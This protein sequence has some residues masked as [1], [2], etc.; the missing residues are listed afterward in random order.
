MLFFT[1]SLG[2]TFNFN[3]TFIPT[4]HLGS[5]L[6]A[7]ICVWRKNTGKLTLFTHTQL[8]SFNLPFVKSWNLSATRMFIWRNPFQHIQQKH[9]VSEIGQKSRF[10]LNIR[11]ERCGE[12]KQRWTHRNIEFFCTLLLSAPP[13]CSSCMPVMPCL[14]FVC[15]H[16]NMISAQW[17]CLCFPVSWHHIISADDLIGF[18]GEE[19]WWSGRSKA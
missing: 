9:W 15:L 14:C 7:W 16:W 18:Y 2:K 13:V 4:S 12:A 8:Y 17:Y 5:P 6:L 11:A 10:F 1:L 19:N 3:K